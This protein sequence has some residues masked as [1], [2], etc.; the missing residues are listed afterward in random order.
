MKGVQEQLSK[1][2]LDINKGQKAEEYKT[3]AR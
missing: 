3:E 2:Y 1:W